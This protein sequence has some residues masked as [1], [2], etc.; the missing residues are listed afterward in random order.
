MAEGNYSVNYRI[1]D[2]TGSGKVNLEKG[3]INGSDAGCVF[4]F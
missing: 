2:R 1:E 3:V 4:R